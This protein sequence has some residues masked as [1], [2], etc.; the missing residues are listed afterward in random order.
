[1]TVEKLGRVDTC[2]VVDSGSFTL[3]LFTHL[4]PLWHDLWGLVKEAFCDGLCSEALT[5]KSSN[6]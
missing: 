3:A 4:E 5:L 2:A 6:F 1:M